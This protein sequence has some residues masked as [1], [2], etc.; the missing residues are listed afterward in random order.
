MNRAGVRFCGFHD[1]AMPWVK[2][3]Q[4][5]LPEPLADELRRGDLAAL[6]KKA[7]PEV[8]EIVMNDRILEVTKFKVQLADGRVG[9]GGIVRDVTERKQAEESLRISEA[10][11]RELADTIPAGVYEATV[12]G[13]FTYANRTAMEMFGYG[14][15]DIRQGIHFLQVVVPE[16][17]DAAKRRS[18]AIRE[19]QDLPYTDYTFVRKDG[20]RFPG[21]LMSKPVKRNGQVVGLMG[22]VTDISA[23]KEA[24]TALRKNEAM[25]QSILKAV[26]VGIAFGRERTLQ[27]SNEYYRRMTGYGEDDVSG[28]TARLLYESEEE[29]QRV[30]KALYGSI[31]KDGI[32]ETQTRW[33]R[34]DGSVIDVLLSVTPLYPDDAAQGV[35]ISALDVTEKKKADGGPPGERDPVSRACR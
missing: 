14:E 11:Y 13:Y 29:F 28:R 4:G 34:Q 16:D 1:E 7:S 8:H 10:R 23:L 5:L 22:V 18:Q 6:R 2:P 30:G 35:V 33:K 17:H 25:L 27:W 12:D 9:V 31:G 15:D 3:I 20:S 24:Q 19:D 32:G 21:L 26:P